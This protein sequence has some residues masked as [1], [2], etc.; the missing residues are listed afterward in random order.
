MGYCI[1]SDVISLL[2][3]QITSKVYDDDI[4]EKTLS[5]ADIQFYIDYA[6]DFIDGA[7]SQLYVTP[8]SQIIITDKNTGVEDIEYPRPIKNICS[9]LAAAYIYKKLFSENQ[10]PQDIPKYA[11]DYESQALKNLNLILDGT[12]SIKGQRMLGR[13]YLRPE[14]RNVNNIVIEFKGFE[15]GR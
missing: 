4:L 10:N 1:I 15:S 12:S 5:E 14:S 3:S 6:T 9:M 13:R 8:L 11:Q 7:I 2:P